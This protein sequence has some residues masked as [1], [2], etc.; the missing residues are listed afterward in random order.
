[1]PQRHEWFS[2]Q[3]YKPPS[4]L[5]CLVLEVIAPPALRDVGSQ[6][7]G[8][9]LRLDMTLPRLDRFTRPG[10]F[11]VFPSVRKEVKTPTRTQPDRPHRSPALVRGLEALLAISLSGDDVAEPVPSVLGPGD[12]VHHVALGLEDGPRSR[13]PR[14]I[15]RI[16]GLTG[17]TDDDVTVSHTEGDLLGGCR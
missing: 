2:C 13:V 9:L 10:T 17:R 7:P 8:S 11:E 1:M 5:G 6:R 16:G 14:H 15:G 12:V 3:R 4:A